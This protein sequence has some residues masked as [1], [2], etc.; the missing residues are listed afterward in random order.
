VTCCFTAQTEI[1]EFWVNEVNLTPTITPSGG[2]ADATVAKIVIFNEPVTPAAIAI[3]GFENDTI[4]LGALFLICTCSRPGSLW[5]FVTQTGINWRSIVAQSNTL[6]LFQTN[7]NSNTNLT[8]VSLGTPS[9]SSQAISL[10]TNQCGVPNS[11]NKL[12][13]TPA[14]QYWAFRRLIDQQICSPSSSPPPNNALVVA[15][16]STCVILSAGLACV[17]FLLGSRKSRFAPRGASQNVRGA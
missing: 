14:A 16:S 9:A 8:G 7:W 17:V 5:N 6:D 10:N 4:K 13:G 15:I 11:A 1:K 12:Q 2:L 3:K